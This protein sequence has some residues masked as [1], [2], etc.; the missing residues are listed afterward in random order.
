MRLELFYR[1]QIKK[2]YQD[3]QE[4]K[5]NNNLKNDNQIG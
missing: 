2:N 1:K 3:S 4:K 5:K